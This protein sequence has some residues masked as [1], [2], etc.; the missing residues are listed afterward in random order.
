MLT[1]DEIIGDKF[2]YYIDDV[3]YPRTVITP[4]FIVHLLF[5]LSLLILLKFLFNKLSYFYIGIIILF[6]HTIYETTDLF[7]YFKKY[8]HYTVKQNLTHLFKI[9]YMDDPFIKKYKNNNSLANSI[10]DT[11]AC[12]FG[13]YLGIVLLKKH[14]MSTLLL[15]GVLFLFSITNLLFY[16]LKLG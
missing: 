10:G 5:G 14:K 7:L 15:T 3:D 16:K 1:L 11:I 12:I 2:I 4:F 8:F 6:I 13:I 9:C